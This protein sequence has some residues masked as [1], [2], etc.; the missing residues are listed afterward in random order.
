MKFYKL[1]YDMKYDVEMEKKGVLLVNAEYC[2]VDDLT[3][4]D[5]NGDK[6][7]NLAKGRF[8]TV[9]YENIKFDLEKN[10]ISNW[11]SPMFYYYANNGTVETEYLNSMYN[12]PIIHES[13]KQA[14]N[15]IGVK[16]VQYLPILLCEIVDDPN[17]PGFGML[18]PDGEMSLEYVAI[19]TLNFIN[20]Y[21]MNLCKYNY[22]EKLNYYFFKYDGVYLDKEVCKDYDIFRCRLDP[23]P[24]YVSE[25]I[26]D[27]VEEKGWKG[28][29]FDEMKTN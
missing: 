27:L 15:E 22:D 6:S 23:V 5:P 12:W 28:F 20:A 11:S 1:T 17:T 21:D 24:L 4:E 13:V 10:K 19:N 2:N 8:H 26:K 9:F 3:Y 7:K 18:N 25:R 14:F 29:C 16:G